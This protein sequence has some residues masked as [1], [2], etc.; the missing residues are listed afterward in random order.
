[1]KRFNE[2]EI[3]L[4]IPLSSRYQPAVPRHLYTVKFVPVVD[5]FDPQVVEVPNL[6]A[7]KDLG[8]CLRTYKPCWCDNECAALFVR[9]QHLCSVY[10][11]ILMLKEEER[12]P[13]FGAPEDTFLRST[14]VS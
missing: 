7:R 10:K 4:L 11:N 13:T 12:N 9:Y 5:R 14:S 8:H 2:A 6:Q 1:M 3:L